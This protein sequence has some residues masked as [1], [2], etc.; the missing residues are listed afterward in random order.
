MYRLEHPK[1]HSIRIAQHAHVSSTASSGVCGGL[2]TNGDIAE[3]GGGALRQG[4]EGLP[5]GGLLQE[6]KESFLE[7]VEHGG[8]EEGQGQE[9]EQLVRELPPV[10][11]GD[12]LPAQL[13]GASHGLELLVG[14]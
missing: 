2:P 3:F 14:V 7:D 9:D 13:D 5:R 6:G 8:A 11:L 1:K 4:G 10:V 12:E